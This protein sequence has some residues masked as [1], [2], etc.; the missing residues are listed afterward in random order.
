MLLLP[1]PKSASCSA[2]VFHCASWMV[3]FLLVYYLSFAGNA[4]L[5][6]ESC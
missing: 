2:N 1:V 4:V 5:V 6:L 3:T